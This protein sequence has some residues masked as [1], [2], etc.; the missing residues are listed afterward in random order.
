MSANVHAEFYHRVFLTAPI[1]RGVDP[2][3]SALL[4]LRQL[5]F[6]DALRRAEQIPF[7][8]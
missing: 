2:Q 7:C 1:G 6:S 5:A 8:V 3:Q 4:F